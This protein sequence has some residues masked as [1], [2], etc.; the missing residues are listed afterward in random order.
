MTIAEGKARSTWVALK[1][2]EGKQGTKDVDKL[3]KQDL[4]PSLEKF[5]KVCKDGK[6]C[7]AIE[8]KKKIEKVLTAYLNISAPLKLA[9]EFKTTI[10]DLQTY[11][12]TVLN[13]SMMKAKVPSGFVFKRQGG[14][15][16]C[17][18]Y[19]LHHFRNGSLS[20]SQFIDTAT[21]F[22]QTRLAMTAE[23]AREL[24]RDGND[25]AVLAAFG[26]NEAA[27]GNGDAYIVA[28]TGGGSAH[29]FVVRKINCMW[30]L[31]DSLKAGP[32]PL[33]DETKAK[34]H[35]AGNKTYA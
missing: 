5:D 1:K 2:K 29:F 32:T 6:F 4:G 11:L 10:K 21:K 28:R 30:W 17:A 20:E 18:F 35:I 19:G 33:G 22:Y 34:S 13:D 16:L 12:T 25:P 31:F 26:V 9:N 3:F 15:S 23:D 14:D 27:F 8:L 24:A 7:E